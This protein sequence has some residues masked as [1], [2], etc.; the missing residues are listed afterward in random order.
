LFYYQFLPPL[1]LFLKKHLMNQRAQRLDQ[2][3]V[4]IGLRVAPRVFLAITGKYKEVFSKGMIR[5]ERRNGRLET[6]TL[7][8]VIMLILVLTLKA[9]DRWKPAELV[10]IL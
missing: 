8:R 9:L 6:L 2:Q 3:A 4:L 1:R 5:M 10:V 7:A